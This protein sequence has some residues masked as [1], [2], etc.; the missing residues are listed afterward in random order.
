MKSS[1]FMHRRVGRSM[2]K[3]P[4]IMGMVCTLMV[5]GGQAVWVNEAQAQNCTGTPYACNTYNGSTWSTVP[6][7]SARTYFSAAQFRFDENATTYPMTSTNT[8]TQTSD[9]KI[10]LT[11]V[12]APSR[13]ASGRYFLVPTA[14]LRWNQARGGYNV[15]GYTEDLVL[16]IK[17]KIANNSY[18]S[19]TGS[20]STAL[21]IGTGTI[22]ALP[23]RGI[24]KAGNIDFTVEIQAVLYA[25]QPASIV[26][27]DTTI[28]NMYGPGGSNGQ[29]QGGLMGEVVI[30]GNP[31]IEIIPPKPKTC[32]TYNGG[33]KTF[34]LSRI[35]VDS[36]TNNANQGNGVSQ[37]VQLVNCPAGINVQLSL[38]DVNNTNSTTNYLVNQGGT[39]RNAG[40]QLF[41][42]NETTAKQLRSP[43]TIRTSVAGNQDLPFTARYYHIATNGALGAGTVRSQAILQVSYP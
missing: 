42:D 5:M 10:Y 19:I 17:A 34:P 18:T 15:A 37:I 16:R 2:S 31:A 38:S 35:A 11:V 3:L 26:I 14:S 1:F 6:G 33:D 9:P 40:V 24:G 30:R 20:G 39:A 8:V 41:Y 13:A 32:D 12:S 43:W 23:T 36:L 7:S 29:S 21:D 22:N 4:T 27:P 25:P 28:F